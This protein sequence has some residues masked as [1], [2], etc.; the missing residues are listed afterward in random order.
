MWKRLCLVAVMSLGSAQAAP[1]FQ[2]DPSGQR[3]VSISNLYDDPA[4]APRPLRVKV[5]KRQFG[6]DASNGR[7]F[8]Y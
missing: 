7:G 8:R 3:V 5:V 1:T 2:F 4:C 6:Q